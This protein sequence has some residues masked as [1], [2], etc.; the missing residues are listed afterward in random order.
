[1]F[2]ILDKN[3][4]N[5]FGRRNVFPKLESAK[6]RAIELNDKFPRNLFRVMELK[7]L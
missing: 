3:Y 1:M 7:T 2:I 5:N 6:G 4:N